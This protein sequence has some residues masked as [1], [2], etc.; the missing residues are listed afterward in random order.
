MENVQTMPSGLANHLKNLNPVKDTAIPTP[1]P[2]NPVDSIPT[3]SNQ[4]EPAPFPTPNIP[5]QEQPKAEAVTEPAPTTQAEPETPQS[6]VTEPTDNWLDPT[7]QGA[8]T[9]NNN[10]TPSPTAEDKAKAFD[11]LFS[12][13]ETELVLKAFQAGKT[14]A[15]LVKEYQVVDYSSMDA[16]A[17]TKI[18]GEQNGY[19][20][21]QMQEWLDTLP[22]IQRDR[23]IKAMR[24]E[25][26]AKEK[27]K[28]K[29]LVKGYE[30]SAELEAQ[31]RQKLDHDLNKVAQ[32]MVDKDLF[33]T[34][35]N[36][37]DADDFPNWVR[38]EFS[39][40]INP[41]G[42]YNV[43]LLRNF[44]L[45][46]VKIPAIQKANY[47]KGKTDGTQAVLKEVHRPNLSGAAA[48]TMP[49]PKPATDPQKK[50][51]DAAKAIGSGKLKPIIS[52]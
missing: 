11:A 4:P 12:H 29:N 19:T 13:P 51:Q 28:T 47:A 37:K 5:P 23:E 35:L 14:L 50:A 34:K 25:L 40:Y 18:Y 3:P 31:V 30:Q 22:T 42:S 1:T 17:V 24:D 39:K 2:E 49:Q 20:E 52:N 6:E 32:A 7:P 36:K 48:T 21:D 8:E 46:A 16:E 26:N 15:D 44:W 27:D 10:N 43:E 45:G 9:P 38:T 33:G 41:D